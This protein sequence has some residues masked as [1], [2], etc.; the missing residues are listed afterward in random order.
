M[1]ACLG[2]NEKKESNTIKNNAKSVSKVTTKE[3]LV[4]SK[5]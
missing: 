2:K 4:I 1:G 5:S 3:E